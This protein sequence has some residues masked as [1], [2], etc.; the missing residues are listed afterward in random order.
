MN[1]WKENI[2]LKLSKNNGKHTLSKYE[3]KISAIPF[4]EQF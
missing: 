1:Q 2:G 4:L 3:T